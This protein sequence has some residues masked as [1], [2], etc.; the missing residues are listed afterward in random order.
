MTD[1]SKEAHAKRNKAEVP[2]HIV[3]DRE[4]ASKRNS[5]YRLLMEKVKYNSKEVKE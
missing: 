4:R 5:A 3:I 1:N 2:R